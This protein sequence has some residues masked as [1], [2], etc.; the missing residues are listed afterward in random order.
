[1]IFLFT[2][3]SSWG[4]VPPQITTDDLRRLA[5]LEGKLEACE[6]NRRREIHLL[7]PTEVILYKVDQSGREEPVRN[8]HVIL[9]RGTHVEREPSGK[10]YYTCQ[11]GF[12]IWVKSG[13]IHEPKKRPSPK[14]IPRVES[15]PRLTPLPEHLVVTVEVKHSGEFTVNHKLD[16]SLLAFLQNKERIESEFQT[17]EPLSLRTQDQ[18]CV[19]L[20]TVGTTT[21][22]IIAGI[23]GGRL[24]PDSDRSDQTLSWWMIGT[25]AAIAA[26]SAM[27][28]D[29]QPAC[30][31]AG[32]TL[33][34]VAGGFLG[35]QYQPEDEPKGVNSPP[36]PPQ[37][38]PG[39][40][41]PP[42]PN[43]PPFPPADP[44]N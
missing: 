28:S 29:D 42:D 34:V 26:V 38:Q 23:G 19:G 43:A 41:P 17:R 36:S 13:S 35:R 5:A 24:N 9:P 1:M 44:P 30:K 33:G 22:G 7:E 18:P 25:G 39:G 4:Q 2:E 16:P 6:N 3:R 14:E 15:A 21:G 11:G 8:G 31:F 20:G 40:I 10:H 12:R 32:F 27:V 37:P